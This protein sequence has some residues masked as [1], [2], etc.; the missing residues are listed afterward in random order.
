MFGCDPAFF[1]AEIMCYL[2]LY[3]SDSVYQLITHVE[4][5]LGITQAVTI[6]TKTRC[7]QA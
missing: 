6:A 2:G 4:P 7:C 1:K 3:E 5:N